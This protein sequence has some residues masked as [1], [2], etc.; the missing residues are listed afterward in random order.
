MK[1]SSKFSLIPRVKPASVSATNVSEGDHSGRGVYSHYSGHYGPTD[2][3]RF[4]RKQKDTA[5]FLS[6]AAV[7]YTHT[8][9]NVSSQSTRPAAAAA[10]D[11]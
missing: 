1:T 6:V 7:I 8:H 3:C 9:T 5:S 10:D 2:V 11:S 4:T